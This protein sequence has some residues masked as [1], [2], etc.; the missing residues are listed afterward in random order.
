MQLT[1]LRLY[2]IVNQPLPLTNAKEG[3]LSLD[4]EELPSILIFEEELAKKILKSDGLV[5]IDLLDFFKSASGLNS[6]DLP[7]LSHFFIKT[8]LL[9]MGENH[10]RSKA[11]LAHI[12]KHI[13]K[14]LSKWVDNFVANFFDDKKIDK[15]I[16]I[17]LID[18][19][20]N[21]I[22]SNY[23]NL[24][25]NKEK[26]QVFQMTKNFQLEYL[27]I[28]EKGKYDLYTYD[29]LYDESYK[30]TKDTHW[31]NT[32]E[33]L[34]SFLPDY[35]YNIVNIEYKNGNHFTFINEN[36]DEIVDYFKKLIN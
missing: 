32:L 23:S 3:W 33:N 17:L 11:S 10:F 16:P 21:Y 29:Q 35:F 5:P 30:Y 18:Q 34:R 28:E 27:G 4:D 12:Y 14:D 15:T 6:S 24:I 36:S 13:E 7:S 31:I 25:D 26:V 22:F 19:H 8:P 20:N 1:L 9:L 2:S